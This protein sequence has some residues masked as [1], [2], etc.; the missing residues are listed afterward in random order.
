MEGV[1]DFLMLYGTLTQAYCLH[2]DFG[3]HVRCDSGEYMPELR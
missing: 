3:P 1:P 2:K